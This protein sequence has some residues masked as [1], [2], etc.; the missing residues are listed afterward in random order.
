[1]K[2]RHAILALFLAAC[3]SSGLVDGYRAAAGMRGSTPIDV[4][5]TLAFCAMAFAWY[6]YD[7]LAQQYRRSKLLDVAVIIASVVAIPYYLARSRPREC[8]LQ[9]SLGSLAS[10]S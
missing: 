6:W 9:Q 7:A 5:W 4:V 1:M 8:D 3:F 2:R 10:R